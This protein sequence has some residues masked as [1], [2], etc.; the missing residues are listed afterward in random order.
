LSMS[1]YGEQFGE[2]TRKVVICGAAGRDFHNFITLFRDDPSVQVVAFTTTQIPGLEERVFPADLAGERYPLGIPVYAESRL[3]AICVQHSV[4]EVVFSYSDVANDEVMSVASVAL[5]AGANFSLLSPASTRLPTAKPSIAVCAVRTGCGK[6][7]T[8]RH[9]ARALSANHRVAV[10]R[11]PMPY[12]DLRRQRVQRF[13]CLADL[14]AANCTLEE[15]EEYE[16]HIQAGGVVFAGVDYQQI[17]A[18]AEA[19][20]DVLLWDGGNNDA[21]FIDCDYNIVVVDALRPEQ[22]T[23]HY[24]GHCVLLGAD[25]VV[26]NKVNSAT[27]AQVADIRA[28]LREIV[29]AAEVVLAGSTVTMAADMPPGSRVLVVED[30]PTITHGGVAYGAGL[31]AAHP[32]ADAICDEIPFFSWLLRAHSFLR[33]GY[34]PDGVFSADTDDYGFRSGT[35]CELIFREPVANVAQQEAVESSIG[36]LKSH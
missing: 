35:A 7:Q 33:F 22:L 34:D 27:T 31:V 10:L 18:A 15:R 17:V 6:S 3:A 23:S 5:A 9:I 19:E 36:N 8:A 24:P 29:P 14:D 12:G 32:I 13:A 28:R 2:Q 26:I 1:Q 25:L 4:T 16:P 11:H 20:C 21:A 30:G